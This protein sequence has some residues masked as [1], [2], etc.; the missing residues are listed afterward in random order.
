LIRASDVTLLHEGRPVV[1]GLSFE[2]DGPDLIAVQGANGSGKSTLLTFLMNQQ[3]I[4]HRGRFE[5]SFRPEAIGFLPQVSDMARTFPLRVID[6]VGTGVW[7]QLKLWQG[8][9]QEMREKRQAV[10]EEMGLWGLRHRTLT[11]LSGGEFQRMLFA[12]LMLQDRPLLLLD[13]PLNNLDEET[14]TLLMEKIVW[15]HQRGHTIFVSLHNESLARAY[16][17]KMLLLGP[18][19]VQFGPTKRL[20]EGLSRTGERYA[21]GAPAP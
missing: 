2:V 19:G 15:L 3:V 14:Q 17:P 5:S 13:E 1:E 12:R 8:F 9:S 10:L 21:E 4:Q 18:R 16:C 20:L 7:P 11:E 6:A